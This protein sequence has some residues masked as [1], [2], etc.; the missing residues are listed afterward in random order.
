M[1][2]KLPGRL[3]SLCTTE[4]TSPIL[5]SPFDILH[6]SF[7]P[8]N[9]IGGALSTHIYAPPLHNA[10]ALLRRRDMMLI[11]PSIVSQTLISIMY[12]V[13]SRLKA[14][15]DRYSHLENLKIL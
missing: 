12:I 11:F 1:V 14:N 5:L 6:R 7:F 2:L 4:K 3:C 9:S 10:L 13:F 15:V 8:R